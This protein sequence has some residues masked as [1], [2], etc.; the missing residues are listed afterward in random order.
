MCKVCGTNM[1]DEINRLDNLYRS[2]AL[3]S[4]FLMNTEIASIAE[5]NLSDNI[6]VLRARDKFSLNLKNLKAFVNG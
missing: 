3:S 1:I 4:S 5:K 6:N 2:L